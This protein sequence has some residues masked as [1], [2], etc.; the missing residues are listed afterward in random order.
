MG[1]PAFW[2]FPLPHT[3]CCNLPLE[4]RE[5]FFRAEIFKK[6]SFDPYNFRLTRLSPRKSEHLK[7]FRGQKDAYIYR[8][9]TKI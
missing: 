1:G 5:P 8:L 2:P 9:N 7:V 4:L 6:V 3:C